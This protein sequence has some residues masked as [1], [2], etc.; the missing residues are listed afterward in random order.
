M[1]MGLGREQG[2]QDQ[3]WPRA[4]TDLYLAEYANFVRLAYAMVGSR[5]RAEEVVQDSFVE[6]GQRW[7]EIDTHAAY[8]RRT[9]V[10]R[11]IAL[12]RRRDVENRHRL[13]VPPAGQPAHLI[14]LRDAI[15]AL[16]QR[17]RAAI[18]LRYVADLDD[19]DIAETL[20]CRAGTV[21]SLISRGLTALRKEVPK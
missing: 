2:R 1:A 8:L 5:D 17:Q 12:L 10:N 13:D 6:L 15:L 18:V 14:E 4:H 19:A 7:D 21:R 9:V 3:P 16:P 11:S 20:G